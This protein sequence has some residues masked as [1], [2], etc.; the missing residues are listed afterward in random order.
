M[1]QFNTVPNKLHVLS[2]IK[3]REVRMDGMTY[4]YYPVIDDILN[5]PELQNNVD[6]FEG[7]VS[8]MFAETMNFSN[9]HLWGMNGKIIAA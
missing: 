6:A 5:D 9:L 4:K 2:T 8:S 1:D 7:E 3:T